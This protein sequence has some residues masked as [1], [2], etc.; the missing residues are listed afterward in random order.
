MRASLLCPRSAVSNFVIDQPNEQ[1]MTRLVPAELVLRGSDAFR[2]IAGLGQQFGDVLVVGPTGEMADLSSLAAALAQPEGPDDVRDLWSD[3]DPADAS[4]MHRYVHSIRTGTAHPDRVAIR[5]HRAGRS[6]MLVFSGFLL[7]PVTAAGAG[8]GESVVVLVA[9]R[10]GASDGDATPSLAQ[11]SHE[12]RAPLTAILGFGRLL[13]ADPVNNDPREAAQFIVQAGE[14]LLEVIEGLTR[15]DAPGASPQAVNA[16]EA[17]VQAAEMLRPMA[18]DHGVTIEHPQGTDGATSADPLLTRQIAI[19]L[20]SNAVKFNRSGGRVDVWCEA[21]GEHRL[22]VYVRDEGLGL[23]SSQIERLFVPYERF[24]ADQRGV[25]GT[26]VGL[27]LAARLA[28]R[29]GGSLGV[30]SSPGLGATFWLE[31]PSLSLDVANACA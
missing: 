19:N 26:G 12:L 3:V 29:I 14:H 27:A 28:R 21:I 1:S 16:L 24:D 31:L 10:S 11:V 22:R 15:R 8:P 4:T 13:E 25:A 20:L 9:D 5:L 2:L 30:T 6:T 18:R 7:S 23:D 17:F